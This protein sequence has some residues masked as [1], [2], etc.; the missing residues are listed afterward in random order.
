MLSE[1][2]MTD[3]LVDLHLT[4]AAVNIRVPIEQKAIRQQY[5]NAVF[6]KHGLTREEFETSLDWYTKNSKQLSAIY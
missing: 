6:E 1:K 4:T 2:E 3:V 5:I